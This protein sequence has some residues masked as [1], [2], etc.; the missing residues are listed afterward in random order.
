MTNEKFIGEVE[1]LKKF[2]TIY[3][4]G[5]YHIQCGQSQILEYKNEKYDIELN[6]CKDCYT[7]IN[8][9]F[10]RLKDC[11]HDEKPRCRTCPSPCYDKK[12]WKALARL[13]SYSGL[14][15]GLTKIKKIFKFGRKGNKK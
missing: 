7:L 11:P 8:Y 5:K 12:E 14:Q 13:M 4:K 10:D 9:S 2:F 1:T 3:C 15:L 6:L